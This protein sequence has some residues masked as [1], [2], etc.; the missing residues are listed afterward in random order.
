[1]LEV[2]SILLG[3]GLIYAIC[4]IAKILG[5]CYIVKICKDN[6]VDTEKAKAF[7][8]MMSKDIK[9]EYPK[10]CVNLQTDVR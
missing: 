7:A 10:V 2:L 9:R 4:Y 3:S 6:N 1:M 8:K 5:Q